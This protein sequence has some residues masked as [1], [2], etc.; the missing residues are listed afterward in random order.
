MKDT[1]GIDAYPYEGT[2]QTINKLHDGLTDLWVVNG[3][4][5]RHIIHTPKGSDREHAVYLY[6]KK[7]ELLK[8]G[9]R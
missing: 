3:S 1:K 6:K 9:E 4:R 8:K 5:G 7:Y 2:N